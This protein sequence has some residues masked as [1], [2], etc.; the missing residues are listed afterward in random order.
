MPENRPRRPKSDGQGERRVGKRSGPDQRPR[1]RGASQGKP[2]LRTGGRP[3]RKPSGRPPRREYDETPR[4]DVQRAYD[5]PEIPEEI[6]GKE[7]DRGVAAALRSLPEKLALRV[8]RHLVAAG[9]L[10]DSDPKLAYQHTQAALARAG[11]LAVVREAV[12]EAAY[13]AGEYAEALSQLR[14][15]KRMNGAWDYLAIMADCERA[16]GRPDRA[17]SLIKGASLE[18]LSPALL[19]EVRIVEAGARRDRGETDAALRVLESA[20]LM[21]KSR[22]PWLARLRYAYADALATDGQLTDAVTWF[23][24]AEAVDVLEATDAGARAA[25]VERQ[26]ESGS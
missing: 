12:G 7:L 15:A 6:T 9:M 4:S 2:G 10:L 13:A 1:G 19:A 11:R 14:A 3:D 5:G 16:L 8:S 22:E 18:K 21:S 26:L 17:L 23:H 24:R 25:E 20:P